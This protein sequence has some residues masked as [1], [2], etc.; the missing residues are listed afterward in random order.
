MPPVFRREVGCPSRVSGA[1]AS[2][3]PRPHARPDERS[4]RKKRG[5][6]LVVRGA[7]A[8]GHGSG[9]R[10]GFRWS[11]ERKAPV[12]ERRDSGGKGEAADEG[13]RSPRLAGAAGGD[14]RRQAHGTPE[15]GEKDRAAARVAETPEACRDGSGGCPEAR[16]GADGGEA[17]AGGGKAAAAILRRLAAA[18]A[19]CADPCKGVW[20]AAPPKPRSEATATRG[21]ASWP[22]PPAICGRGQRSE[23]ETC[24][25]PPAILRAWPPRAAAPAAAQKRS[26]QP[27]YPAPVQAA[28]ARRRPPAALLAGNAQDRCRTVLTISSPWGAR[29]QNPER[30]L[31]FGRSP[32]K[33]PFLPPL[34]CGGGTGA[35][36]AARFPRPLSCGRA[37]GD[38]VGEDRL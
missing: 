1:G 38:R 14:G 17:A 32:T 4:H 12:R 21:G 10:H 3:W 26:G 13:G 19:C 7:C 30:V 34:S 8:W 20:G 23:P 28:G 22:S 18:S 16:A 33:V 27:R 35:S 6:K 9:R 31:V 5:T 11:A 2:P 25:S 29:S 24:P 15:T 37:G 36:E